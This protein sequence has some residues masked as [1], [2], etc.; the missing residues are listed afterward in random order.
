[1]QWK[2]INEKLKISAPA[3]TCLLWCECAHIKPRVYEI[4]EYARLS[5][6]P[7][8]KVIA[9]AAALDWIHK[10]DLKDKVPAFRR[11]TYAVLYN[12]DKQSFLDLRDPNR[13]LDDTKEL[14]KK[15]AENK[16]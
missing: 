14:A 12:A 10:L 13:N 5:D 3:E 7:K 2:I 15:M 8:I 4:L 1:M 6:I 11:G 16:L 9:S